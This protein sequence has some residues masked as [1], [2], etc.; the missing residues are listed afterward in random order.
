MNE[1]NALKDAIRAAIKPNGE[2]ALTAQVLQ[3]ILIAIVNSFGKGYQFMGIATADTEPGEP[4]EKEFY[5]GFAGEYANFVSETVTVPVGGVVIFLYDT[6]WH[7]NVVKVA[8]RVAVSDNHLEIDGARSIIEQD[9]VNINTLTSQGEAFLTAAAARAAVSAESGLRIGGQVITYLVE[10][11]EEHHTAWVV[12]Q[13]TGDDA[14]GWENDDNWQPFLYVELAKIVSNQAQ[15]NEAIMEALGNRY[16]KEQVDGMIEP[17]S[18]RMGAAEEGLAAEIQRAQAEESRL[19]D[20]Y[21]ALTQNP[22][23]IGPLPSSGQAN[24]I[25]RVPGTSSYS[26]YM[27]N[28]TQFVLMATYSDG[29]LDF[30]NVNLLNATGSTPHAA[31]ATADAARA[32][33][34]AA[35]GLRALGLQITYLLTDGV[36]YT[37]QYI[38]TDISG[39]STASNWKTL[40]PVS[41]SQNTETGHT[42]ISVGGVTTP[43]PSVEELGG[44]ILDASVAVTGE[45]TSTI[46][47]IPTT[48]VKVSAGKTIR[49]SMPET[50][51][52]VDVWQ[53]YIN[54]GENI[55]ASTK[56][57]DVL[58]TE[59]LTSFRVAITHPETHILA[60]GTIHCALSV[61]GIKTDIRE[62]QDDVEG[63]SSDVEGLS[64]DVDNL[65]ES[66][67]DVPKVEI[68][69]PITLTGVA[70]MPNKNAVVGTIYSNNIGGTASYSH[71]VVSATKGDKFRVG[72]ARTDSSNY[73]YYLFVCDSDDYILSRTISTSGESGSYET[74]V[75]I[76]DNNAAKIVVGTYG[77]VEFFNEKVYVKKY[78]YETDSL[79]EQINVIKNNEDKG[80]NDN[81]AA[82][83]GKASSQGT[84]NYLLKTSET[85]VITD[86]FSRVA[87]NDANHSCLRIAVISDTHQGGTYLKRGDTS[88][89]SIEMFKRVMGNA[90][91]DICVHCGDLSTDYGQSHDRLMELVSFARDVFGSYNPLIVSKG[92]H[93]LNSDEYIQV[94][95]PNWQGA[96]TYY[97]LNRIGN[98]ASRLHTFNAITESEWDGV[99]QLYKKQ[100][101]ERYVTD[102]EFFKLVNYNI[103]EGIVVD[104]NNEDGAYFYLDFDTYKVRLIVLNN[105]PVGNDKVFPDTEL[106]GKQFAWLSKTALDLS[107]K[108]TPSD[109]AVVTVGHIAISSYRSA[110]IPIFT[111]IMS[112]FMSGTN[113]SG[114][115]GG[116]DYSK[117]YSEQGSG[118]YVGNLHGHNH[119]YAYD[120]TYGF[121]DIGFNWSIIDYDYIG[122]S[123]ARTFGIVTIDIPNR[124][125]YDTEVNSENDREYS[126]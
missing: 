117:D 114:T 99:T 37:D 93:E 36:W 79:Q 89:R 87:E 82:L 113:V 85:S 1:Y 102:A 107:E 112:A 6:E 81:V 40:G 5:V 83:Q 49:I 31:Y 44:K 16:T 70:G 92:N 119:S 60:S 45:E 30:I 120:D 10:T 33:I 125:V 21:D 24:T 56:Y 98:K 28:G 109:W 26:D 69:T 63:L 62:L 4:D 29:R 68:L 76:E 55:N 34:S 38:G 2:Y 52:L 39:W 41:V 91:V 61:L 54:G 3:N 20:Q 13:F 67:G 103:P 88:E 18:E 121:N 17:L 106:V 66:V 123:L 7:A 8:E 124:K 48:D 42:D 14:E 86:I 94:D 108:T 84:L 104:T 59:P 111:S 97:I 96:D 43:V 15:I 19:Q 9:I 78:S 53:Y 50:G 105:Y 32:D 118:K 80:S 72:L 110:Y 47:I 73:P 116:S 35:S 51:T 77:K 65:E 27:W 75:V 90:G 64:S 95:Y 46:N 25:Y 57:V 58:L 11:D 100:G 22:I 71:C 126:F 101:D 115:Y 122:E 23:V 12:D 74:D